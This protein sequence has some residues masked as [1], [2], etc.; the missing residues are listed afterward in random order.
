[1]AQGVVNDEGGELT[2]MINGS[3]GGEW[4]A[5]GVVN[6]EGGEKKKMVN[7]SRGGE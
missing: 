4:L 5:H 6:D 2:K 1:M 7:G 3:R